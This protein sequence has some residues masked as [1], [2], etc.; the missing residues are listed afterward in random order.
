[1]T[2]RRPLALGLLVPL[3]AL[4]LV[5]AAAA[6]ASA[7]SYRYWTYWHGTSAGGW[8]FSPVGATYRPAD[9]S[10]EGWRFAVSGTAASTQPRMSSSFLVICAGRT[11]TTGNKLVALVVD[12]GT[13][14]EAPQGEQ[15]PYT[16]PR[17][18]C[19][20]VAQTANAYAILQLYSPGAG[21]IRSAGGLICGIHGYP[22]RE[23][24][25]VVAPLP[26]PTPTPKPTSQPS[27][28]PHP[29]TG[30]GGTSASSRASSTTSGRA[31]ATASGTS[32][33]GSPTAGSAV[34]SLSGS[35]PG[36]PSGGAQTTFPAAQAMGSEASIDGGSGGGVPWPS[37]AGGALVVLLG[38]AAV[39]R[40]RRSRTAGSR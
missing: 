38:G 32:A 28:L 5:L 11:A 27:T 35:V 31:S 9:K 29:T 6:P 39:V 7:A 25:V 12:Y 17:T 34:P 23:C 2:R 37:L 24:G 16:A 1:M 40:S 10:V 19:A 15:P 26:S 4:A 18:Y 21:G 20:D 14:T 22:A 13:S 36:G 30:A 3:A 8:T 33:P